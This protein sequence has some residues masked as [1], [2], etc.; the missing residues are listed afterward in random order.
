MIRAVRARACFLAALMAVACG[1]P[2][3]ARPPDPPAASTPPEPPP[4]PPPP[5]KCESLAE[6]CA[7][8]SG[9]KARVLDSGVSV[10]PPPGW[11]YAQQPDATLATSDGAAFAVTIHRVGDP[12]DLKERLTLRLAALDLLLKDAGLTPPRAYYFWLKPAEEVKKVGDLK[13]TIWQLDDATDGAKK[14]SLVVFVAPLAPATKTALI[15]IGFV[16]NDDKSNADAAI[17]KAIDT[18]TVAAGSTS[19]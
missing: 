17:L 6:H 3:P 15:G 16:P 11:Q 9:T 7:A 13:V 10:E 1:S 2:K 4:P 12:R 8:E 18:I 19:P 14:G 5:P